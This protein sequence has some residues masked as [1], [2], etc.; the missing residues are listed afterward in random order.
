MEGL[1]LMPQD[2]VFAFA[3]R[4][5]TAGALKRKLSGKTFS[6]PKTVFGKRADRA[7]IEVHGF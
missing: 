3:T 5:V 4:I 7:T 1:G 2:A 6:D